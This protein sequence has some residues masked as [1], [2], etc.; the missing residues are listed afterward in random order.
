MTAGASEEVKVFKRKE[1]E[2]RDV[3]T[4]DH[5]NTN[6]NKDNEVQSMF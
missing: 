5:Y 2:R 3:T 4:S 6:S 1:E